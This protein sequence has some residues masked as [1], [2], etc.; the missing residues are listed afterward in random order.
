MALYSILLIITQYNLNSVGFDLECPY[1]TFRPSLLDSL[2]DTDTREFG[3]RSP[4]KRSSHTLGNMHARKG[5]PMD[6]IVNSQ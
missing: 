2:P 6:L 1:V 3:Y 4:D 5:R